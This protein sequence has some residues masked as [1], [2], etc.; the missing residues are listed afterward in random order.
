MR[1][2][3]YVHTFHREGVSAIF[4]A[5]TF[6]VA[7]LSTENLVEL[8]NNPQDIKRDFAELHEMLKEAGFF[9]DESTDEE[10]S[11]EELRTRMLK[12]ISLELLYLLVTDGCNLRCSY[13]FEDAPHGANTTRASAMSTS[14]IR[15]SINIFS[16][17]SQRH[18]NPTKKKVIHLYGGEPMVNRRGVHEAIRYIQILKQGGALPAD[19]QATIVTNGVLLQKSDVELFAEHG[20]TVGLSVDGPPDIT[21]LH[22]IPKRSGINVHEDI[23]R[24]FRL[25]KTHGVKTGLS[26]TITPRALECD[27]EFLDFF[28]EGEFAQADGL[29][30]NLLHYTPHFPLPEGYYEQAT[31]LQ[32]K[33]FQ[34]FREKG[35]YEERIMRK[36]RAFVDRMPAYADCGVVG[37][38]LVI[39][40]D[41]KIGVCQD[42]V[43][44]RTYFT[45]SVF[46][47]NTDD[48]LEDLFA[49]WRTRSP[50]YMPDCQNCS[51]IGIC[52]GGCPASAEMRTGNRFNLDERA[53]YH[54]RQVLEWLIWDAY[55]QEA[56]DN[57]S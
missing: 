10:A 49:A 1:F 35:I 22:R 37:Y 46:D 45:R 13:C 43:K 39:A 40:P 9:V 6:E 27:E 38:Q 56:T 25:L 36:A 8:Q 17:M 41:G 28:T 26:A 50:F 23:V 21:N 29:S 51:A 12:S 32:I 54:S 14:T 34:R 47:E 57:E 55:E 4:H 42:F 33:A 44:P 31:T 11:F 19:C 18:G 53:C 30:L 5:L 24:A 48:L 15:R 16:K 7:Y 20:V 3:K 2:S 52:G